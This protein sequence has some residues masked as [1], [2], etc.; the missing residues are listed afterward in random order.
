M[1]THGDVKVHAPLISGISKNDDSI[2]GILIDGS[3]GCASVQGDIIL[4]KE[5]GCSIDH[6]MKVNGNAHVIVYVWDERGPGGAH[7][8]SISSDIYN[9]VRVFEASGK[10][11]DALRSIIG[12]NITISCCDKNVWELYY[13]SDVLV[14]WQVIYS[15]TSIA[16][17]AA[18]ISFFAI[19][20]Q[21]GENDVSSTKTLALFSVLLSSLVILMYSMI[22]PINSSGLYP[23][24]FQ[25]ILNTAYIWPCFTGTIAINSSLI[26]LFGDK[27]TL[28][29]KD[30]WLKILRGLTIT[31][32]TGFIIDIILS[33]FRGNYSSA[34][35]SVSILTALT[36]IIIAIFN[37]VMYFILLRRI[38]K[39][40]LTALSARKTT[41]MKRF[42]LFSGMNVFGYISFI[43]MAIATTLMFRMTGTTPSERLALYSFTF[44]TI[45][46]INT[47]TL[48]MTYSTQKKVLNSTKVDMSTSSVDPERKDG[49]TTAG[50]V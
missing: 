49:N 42:R 26:V 16:Y 5:G 13:M 34:A 38:H 14:F 3:D 36:Y 30:R 15:G 27:I 45:F 6:K 35:S 39:T 22:D 43:I 37:I 18:S 32:I 44:I 10:D 1:I 31:L 8:A 4:V 29:N 41:F 12:E 25:H 21:S 33:Y 48:I 2:R 20:I 40:S 46:I 11:E 23:L 50:T 28:F 17:I 47:S 19:S 9:D 24:W 7:I